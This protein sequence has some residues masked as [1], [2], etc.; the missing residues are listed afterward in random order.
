[1]LLHYLGKLKSQKVALCMHVK[2]V[3]NVTFSHLSSRYLCVQLQLSC[4]MELHSYLHQKLFIF[5]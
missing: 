2:H 4:N 1:M 5:V 3:S